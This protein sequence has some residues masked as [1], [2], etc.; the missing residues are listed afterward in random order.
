VHLVSFLWNDEK[1][2]VLKH[3]AD[4][5]FFCVHITQ[6]L[7]SVARR[8]PLRSIVE[9]NKKWFFIL[10][11]FQKTDAPHFVAKEV[12]QPVEKSLKT[13]NVEKLI[14]K[15]TYIHCF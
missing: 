15:T 9:R 5:F 10:L 13:P 8:C 6:E 11:Q 7:C 1:I 3:F 12:N 14:K 2:Q 4:V